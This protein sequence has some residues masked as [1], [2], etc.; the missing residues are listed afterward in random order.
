MTPAEGAGAFLVRVE[1][2]TACF[3]RCRHM[4][5]HYGPLRAMLSTVLLICS[6]LMRWLV[7]LLIILHQQVLDTTM[8][9]GKAMFQMMG[10]STEFERAMIRER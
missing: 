8:P 1:N 3:C 2:A 5:L 6:I 7:A 9:A 10:A 4:H